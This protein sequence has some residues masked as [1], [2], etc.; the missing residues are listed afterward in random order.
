MM[1]D[2]LYEPE[3]YDEVEVIDNSAEEEDIRKLQE[4]AADLDGIVMEMLRVKGV[5][6]LLATQIERIRP[7]H[8]ESSGL[9]MESFTVDLSRTNYNMTM[10]G[11][12]LISG[13]LIAGAIAII[14]TIIVKIVKW[15]M[16]NFGDKDK[17]VGAA[18]GENAARAVNIQATYKKL[19]NYNA[20][21]IHNMIHSHPDL[22]EV[23]KVKHPTF[24][25]ISS[26][27]NTIKTEHVRIFNET[28][29]S[30]RNE[31]VRGLMAKD[32]NLHF[33]FTTF[34]KGS[35]T[36]PDHIA[37]LVEKL[38]Q[39]IVAKQK[40]DSNGYEL[41]KHDFRLVAQKLG[42]HDVDDSNA[43]HLITEAIRKLTAKKDGVE[44][45]MSSA[46]DYDFVTQAKEG[47]TFDSNKAISRLNDCN[48]HIGQLEE[49]VKHTKASAEEKIA[50]QLLKRDC[51]EMAAVINTFATAFN[52]FSQFAKLYAK[53]TERR[54]EFDRDI[55]KFM[56][57]AK[58]VLP[59]EKEALKK[60]ISDINLAIAESRKA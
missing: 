17:G 24:S 47:Q 44:I 10:E 33:F 48:M 60:A 38:Q 27:E 57:G 9:I 45:S 31:F 25:T 22:F 13:A 40:I 53:S 16:A 30:V 26:I 12:G 58:E 35:N 7:G 2:T 36:F 20:R 43:V 50:V 18:A 32:Q 52:Q 46:D 5:N 41:P 6:K 23:L 55:M 29:E 21:T 37:K 8:L 14:A 28:V 1:E 4:K 11:I 54:L 56:I 51:T 39:S 59:A 15:L 49:T 42:A 3:Y 19:A 34:V